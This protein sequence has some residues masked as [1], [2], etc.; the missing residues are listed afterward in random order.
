MSVVKDFNHDMIEG[1]LK[2]KDLNYLRDRDRGLRRP[3]RQQ[4]TDRL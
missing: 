3:V 2:A 1:Y 4:L